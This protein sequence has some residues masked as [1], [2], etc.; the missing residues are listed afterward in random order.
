[1]EPASDLANQF[2]RVIARRPAGELDVDVAL[3]Q[4]HRDQL[5]VPGPAE[6]GRNDGELRE[7][8]RHGVQVDRPC[9][10]E[11][12]ALPARLGRAD[13]AGA[14]VK[15]AWNLQLGGLLPELEVPLVARI[16]VLHRGM[17]L[18]TL[19][20]ELVD[21]AFKLLDGVRLPGIHRGEE[22]ESLGVAFDD[23]AYE[24]VGKWRPV[25][26]RLRI[27]GEQDPKDL[28]L[29]KLDGELIDAALVDVALKV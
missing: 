20:P 29:G 11:L 21:G 16:E 13:A 19:R 17:E 28:L 9:R 26:G 12:D 22:S 4:R 15:K 1:L 24:V 27:P 10:V 18:G 6:V 14:S 2:L 25:G 7:V 8:C 5:Q 23:P 3:V